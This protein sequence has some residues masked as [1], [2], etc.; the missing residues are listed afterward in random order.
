M[1]RSIIKSLLIVIVVIAVLKFAAA[2]FFIPYF[3]EERDKAEQRGQETMRQWEITKERVEK[4]Q[5]EVHEQYQR[6]YEEH[7]RNK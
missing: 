6:N 2:I 5:K 3:M 7:Q 1:N 4:G